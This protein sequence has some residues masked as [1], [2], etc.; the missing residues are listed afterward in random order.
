[1]EIAIVGPQYREVGEGIRA[2]DLDL[3]L[4]PV[5]EGRA[6]QASEPATT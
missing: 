3:D 6:R 5:D 2:D 4:A 1:M